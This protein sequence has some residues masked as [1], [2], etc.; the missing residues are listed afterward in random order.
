MEDRGGREDELDRSQRTTT[1]SP[2]VLKTMTRAPALLQAIGRARAQRLRDEES[3]D[4]CGDDDDDSDVRPTLRVVSGKNTA[5]TKTRIR[6]PSKDQG[7]ASAGTHT[8]G[9]NDEEPSGA[10]KLISMDARDA[11]DARRWVALGTAACA[12]IVL[13]VVAIGGGAGIAVPVDGVV[14]GSQLSGAPRRGSLPAQ[15]PPSQPPPFG[16]SQSPPPPAAPLSMPPPSSSPPPPMQP[17]PMPSAPPPVP[18]DP[19]ASP[20]SPPPLPP[21]TPS[22]LPSPP[23]WQRHAGRNCWWAGHGAE[24]VDTPRGSALRGVSSIAACLAA[25]VELD[26]HR[27]HGVLWRGADGSCYRKANIVE[28]RCSN[29]A[30]YDLYMRTDLPPPPP[31]APGPVRQ[32]HFG[33]AL[34]ADKMVTNPDDKFYR[35]W[36]GNAWYLTAAGQGNCWGS[37]PTG[38]FASVDRGDYCDQNWSLGVGG[39]LGGANARPDFP[40]GEAPALLG[41]DE[42]IW[43]FCQQAT[44]QCAQPH[45]PLQHPLLSRPDA[46]PASKRAAVS[47]VWAACAHPTCA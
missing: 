20:L 35:M 26:E 36:G 46:T 18:A 15:T 21:A 27:C 32:P 19:P 24:E 1:H 28:A 2:G 47:G 17:L 37:D 5:G 45:A 31:H 10:P 23:V 34:Q 8:K 11:R 39:W 6:W 22:P 40:G 16:H 42:T 12:C 25:C 7:D 33:N 3:C 43:D 29:D 38:W 30:H 13:G 44:G 4:E 9:D 14:A 41:F